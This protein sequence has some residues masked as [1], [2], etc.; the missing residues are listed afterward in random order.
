MLSQIIF[1]NRACFS[2][3]KDTWLLTFCMQGVFFFQLNQFCPHPLMLFSTMWMSNI[4]EV[5]CKMNVCH[6]Q[7]LQRLRSGARW[8]KGCGT[9][10]LWEAGLSPRPGLCISEPTEA[11]CTL[12]PTHVAFILDSSPEPAVSLCG[13]LCSENQQWQNLPNSPSSSSS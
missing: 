2:K 1:M 4:A 10:P 12:E 13:R 9:V 7:R 11:W 6:V 5:P 8:R 3:A